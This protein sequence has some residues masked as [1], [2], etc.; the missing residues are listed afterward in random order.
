MKWTPKY[1]KQCEEAEEI[2]RLWKPKIGDWVQLRHKTLKKQVESYLDPLLVVEDVNK[3][4]V[5]V[6]LPKSIYEK[7][8][9]KLVNYRVYNPYY[10]STNGW[11]W[12]VWLPTQSQ[13]QE[14]IGIEPYILIEKFNKWFNH[15]FERL[16]FR[17]S[18][19]EW[20]MEQFWLSFCQEVLYNKIWDE[21]KEKWVKEDK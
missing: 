1:I 8:D 14:I 4:A 12:W 19:S 10:N 2:Q 16:G 7:T 6:Y 18:P 15:T 9:L 20:T 11:W 3:D 21:K 5:Y 17:P 13:L